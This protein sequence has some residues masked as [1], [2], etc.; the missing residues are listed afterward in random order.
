LKL[1]SFF[2]IY[3][4]FIEFLNFEIFGS[5]YEVSTI[6]QNKKTRFIFRTRSQATIQNNDGKKLIDHLI[7]KEV[8][9]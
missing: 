2:E 8:S 7:S 3:R 4:F 5:D 6:P 9:V 1:R